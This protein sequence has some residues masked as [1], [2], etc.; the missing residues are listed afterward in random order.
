MNGD[1]AGVVELGQGFGFTGEPLGKRGVVSNPGRE[2]FER[3][4][5][6]KFLLPRFIDC[7]H[8]TASDQFDE[9]ELRELPRQFLN[10][11]R[12]EAWCLLAGYSPGSH[13][14]FHQTSRAKTPRGIGGQRSLAILANLLCV[15]ILFLPP[16]T[17]RIVRACYRILLHQQHCPLH[18]PSAQPFVST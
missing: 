3:H 10:A 8:A 16:L 13:C 6:V 17:E 15:H 11:R 14:Q 1:D 18:P 5:A 7:P 9:F 2:D 4:D 12:R